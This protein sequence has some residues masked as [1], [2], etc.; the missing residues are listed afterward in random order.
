MF[1]CLASVA[2]QHACC[3]SCSIVYFITGVSGIHMAPASGIHTAPVSGIHMAPASGIH[4]APASGIHTTPVSGI[5]T[6]PVSGIHTAPA[7]GIH[8][9]PAEPSAQGLCGSW[10]WL[11]IQNI[12]T[13][14]PTRCKLSANLYDIYHCC[15]YSEKLLML[16]RGTV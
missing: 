10:E 7:S 15:M 2:I 9:A 12:P 1:I 8:M 4:T 13:I 3:P 16:D 5:H 14:K 11:H 6:A